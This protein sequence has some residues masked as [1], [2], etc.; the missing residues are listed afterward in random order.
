MPDEK[1]I[2]NGGPAFP[3]TMGEHGIEGGMSVR[4]YFAGQALPSLL[5]ERILPWEDVSAEKVANAAYAIA[6]AMLKARGRR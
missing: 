1:Q 5:P 2:D 6:D 3:A 4:D